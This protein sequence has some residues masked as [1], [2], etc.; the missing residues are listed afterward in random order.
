VQNIQ[1]RELQP[2]KKPSAELD[3]SWIIQ[4]L[5]ALVEERITLLLGVPELVH[6]RTSSPYGCHKDSVPMHVAERA[7]MGKR[8]IRI[9]VDIFASYLCR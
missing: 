1:L 7:G 6:W 5:V 8:R 4:G 9:P 3:E 2:L